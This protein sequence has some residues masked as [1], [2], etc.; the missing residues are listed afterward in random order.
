MRIRGQGESGL[1][2]EL[3]EGIDPEVSAHVRELAR[4]VA[5][6]LA[7]EVL[8][9]VPTYRSLLVLHDPLRVA[10][11]GLVQRIGALAAE[12]GAAPAPG[13]RRVVRIPTCY[14]GTHG[15]DLDEVARLAGLDAAEVVR[16]HAAPVYL[17]HF[18]GFTP[19]FPYLGGLD[20]RLATPR[21]DEPRARVPAGSV[22]IGGAQAGIYPVESPGGW[23]VLGRTPLRLFDPRRARPF[24]LSAGD[25]LRFVPVD[26]A[27]FES[28]AAEAEAGRLE[29]EV[30]R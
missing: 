8:E 20:P 19:G 2:V 21:R 29:A 11:D 3:G 17:V 30:E 22:A 26:A 14:G 25:G 13:P 15:P 24:L 18:L 12:V 27:A 4:A 5:E 16:Y 23:R 10:R 7:G 28:L 6:R 9:V 1:V